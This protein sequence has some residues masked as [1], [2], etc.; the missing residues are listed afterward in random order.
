MKTLK[1]IFGDDERKK[2]ID[3]FS[4]ELN[5]NTMLMIKGGDEDDDLW[6]PKDPG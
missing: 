3:N 1:D 6:P 2:S 4:S 5:L